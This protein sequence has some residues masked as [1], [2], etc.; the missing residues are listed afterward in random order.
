MKSL[1]TGEIRSRLTASRAVATV[2]IEEVDQAKP[3]AEALIAGGIE[4][5]EI[6]LRTPAALDAMKAIANSYPQLMIMAGTVITPEQVKQVQDVGAVCAVAPGL[7]RRVIEAALTAK[8]PFAPG[9]ATPSEIE[10]ALE[11]DCDILKFFPAEPM[12]GIGYLKSMQ[13]PYAHLGLQFIPLGGLH[14]DNAENYLKESCILAVGGSWIAK[15]DAISTG[16]WSGIKQRAA[17]VMGV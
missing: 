8:M 17:A 5:V 6:T 10:A 9:V 2:T 3:L 4:C 12:G 13:A 11:Y 14:A 1:F 15:A 7:N 16:D